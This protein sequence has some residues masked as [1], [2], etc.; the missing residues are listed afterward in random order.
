[1]GTY[2]DTNITPNHI[3]LF[4]DPQLDNKLNIKPASRLYCKKHQ[5][6]VSAKV[7]RDIFVDVRV[8]FQLGCLL[9]CSRLVLIGLSAGQRHLNASIVISATC[10]EPSDGTEGRYRAS[11]MLI[12][13]IS[14]FPLYVLITGSRWVMR[15]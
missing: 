11:N 1:M 8:C 14:E 7:F 2:N 4:R 6:C 15:N 3:S 10:A 5:I 12:K 9:K 13:D